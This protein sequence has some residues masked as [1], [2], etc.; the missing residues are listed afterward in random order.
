MNQ[1]QLNQSANPLV[2]PEAEPTDE[3]LRIDLELEDPGFLSSKRQYKLRY[4]DL[5]QYDSDSARSLTDIPAIETLA[6]TSISINV[7][8]LPKLFWDVIIII[9]DAIIHSDSSSCLKVEIGEAGPGSATQAYREKR[10]KI[11]FIER[12]KDPIC[13]YR[14]LNYMKVW[15][16]ILNYLMFLTN[17]RNS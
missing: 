2:V 11:Q 3:M 1:Y 4:H 8:M 14:L 9:W 16:L 12:Q 6:T 17:N 13:S 7:Y 5:L 10:G 15:I